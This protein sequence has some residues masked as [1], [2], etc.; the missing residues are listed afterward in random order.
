MG[1]KNIFFFLLFLAMVAWGGSWVNVKIL[2]HYVSAFEMIFLRFGIT[3]ITMVPIIVWL[4]HS[5]KIDLKSFG[6]VVLAALALIFY[7]KYYYLGTKFG[8]ASLGG[9]MVTTMIP[10]L[11][12][13]FL[14]LMGAKKVSTKDL[15]ALGLGAVGVLTMLHIWTFDLAHILVIHNLYFLLAAILWAVLTIVSS[16]STKISPIV[17][18]FYMYIVTVVLDWVLFVDVS[19][20]PFGSFDGIFWLNTLLISLAAST[21]ANTIFFLGIEKLGAAEVSSFVFL[22]PFSAI[23][24]SAVFLGEKVD[25][26]I[27]IGTVLTLYAV[28]LLNNIII[29]KRHRKSV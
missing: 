22:V 19:T 2:G 21:F 25:L 5:F 23:I 27:I 6:L 17:F 10:I 9:A 24:L 16:K 26:F 13:I 29:L 1:N 18:T 14:A 20:I 8:T 15:F 28:K 3:A 12:F 11:T 7:N 4:K